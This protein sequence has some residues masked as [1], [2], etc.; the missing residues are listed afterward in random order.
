MVLVMTVEPGFG[1]QSLRQETLAKMRGVRALI[2]QYKPGCELEVDGGVDVHTAPLV[3]DSGASVLV[4]GSA[5][6]GRTDRAAAMDEL[7]MAAAVK[8]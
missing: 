4:A 7:R 5:V 6:F 2:D 1:G 3:V 8:A